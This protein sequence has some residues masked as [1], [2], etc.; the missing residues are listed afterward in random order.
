MQ[1]Q[2]ARQILFFYVYSP[3][4]LQIKNKQKQEKE[5]DDFLYKKGKQNRKRKPCM[6]HTAMSKNDIV[7]VQKQT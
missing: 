3:L 7:Q 1:N 2:A 6:V 4:H 5:T